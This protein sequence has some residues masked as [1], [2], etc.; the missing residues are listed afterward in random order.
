MEIFIDS[1]DLGE[2]QQAHSW[3]CITGVTT[4]PKIAASQKQ[5]YN[6]KDRIL[7]IAGLVKYPLSVEVIPEDISGMLEEAKLY[8]SWNENIVVKI[9]MSKEGLEVTSILEREENIRVNL[10]AIMATNQAILAAL[11]GASYA[12][13]FYGRISDLGYDPGLVIAETSSLYKSRGVQTKIIVGSI[14]SM[15]DVNKAF[16]AGADIVTV[17]FRFLKQMAEHPQTEQTIKEFND[18]WREMRAKNLIHLEDGSVSRP[19]TLA[20]VSK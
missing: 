4:N 20:L 7:Q 6:F 11:S 13:I 15:L 16:L 12:S 14:R 1:A 5:S 18:S 2:I 19:A 3:G 9:P 10:T 17:P 8:A